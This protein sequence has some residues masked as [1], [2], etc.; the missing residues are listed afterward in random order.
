MVNYVESPGGCTSTPRLGERLS[1]VLSCPIQSYIPHGE[2]GTL[3][4]MTDETRLVEIKA[5]SDRLR[6][7][8]EKLYDLLATKFKTPGTWSH[9]KKSVGMYW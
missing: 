3:G 8:R 5:M 2:F 6:S 7:V 4:V 9:I 1:R